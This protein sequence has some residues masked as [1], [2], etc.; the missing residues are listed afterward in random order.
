MDVNPRSC[1]KLKKES[2][3]HKGI[4]EVADSGTPILCDFAEIELVLQ[5][6]NWGRPTAGLPLQMTLST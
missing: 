3:G 6:R 4:P 5:F 1:P 2:L